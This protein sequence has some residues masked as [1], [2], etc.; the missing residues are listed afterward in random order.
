M[1]FTGPC[2][3]LKNF[4]LFLFLQGTWIEN[5]VPS[6]AANPYLVLAATVA[7]GIDGIRNKIEPPAM[8]NKEASELPESLEEA[9]KA[10]ETDT[11]FVQELGEHFVQW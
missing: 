9:L 10:L 6:A 11:V 2:G 1:N 7:A 5:R 8:D 4:M 3:G